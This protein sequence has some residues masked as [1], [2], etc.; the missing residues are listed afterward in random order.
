[1][2]DKALSAE[3]E[4]VADEVERRFSSGRLLLS[5]SEYLDLFSQ[6]PIRQTRDASRYVRDVF[7]HYGTTQVEHPF[8]K[9]T[10]FNLF[11]LPWE[12][13]ENGRLPR[14]AL[15]GQEAVQ[16]EVYRALS[17][18]AREGRPGRLLLLHGPNGSAKS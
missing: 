17:N 14:G 16:G 13:S 2:T 9:F 15:I 5:F 3:I 18:F 12:K 7:D 4:A 8:G 1:M 10:R 11:D 6:E